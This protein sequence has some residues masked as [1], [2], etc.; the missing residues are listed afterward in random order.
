M[1]KA[2]RP[3]GYDVRGRDLDTKRRVGSKF[4]AAQCAMVNNMLGFSLMDKN[5]NE[6]IHKR[7]K[8]TDIARKSK[9]K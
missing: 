7:K 5:G 4:Q 8:I 3:T 6:N 9:L 1:L 2:M